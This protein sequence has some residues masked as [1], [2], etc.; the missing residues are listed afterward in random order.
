MDPREAYEQGFDDAVLL[1]HV[2]GERV[3]GRSGVIV[4]HVA[5]VAASSRDD[6]TQKFE[7]RLTDA[8]IQEG[9]S[10]A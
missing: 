3:G 1:V 4:Q 7:D 6:M 2:A 10:D 8:S 5:T 9:N